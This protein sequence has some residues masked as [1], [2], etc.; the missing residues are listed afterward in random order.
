MA[1]ELRLVKYKSE[2]ELCL[3]ALV[4]LIEYFL[5]LPEECTCGGGKLRIAGRRELK[6]FCP[7]RRIQIIIWSD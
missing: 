3:E 4:F 7:N 2:N 6:L 1:T 5:D